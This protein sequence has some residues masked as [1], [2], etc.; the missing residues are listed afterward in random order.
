MAVL[1]LGLV[2]LC[3]GAVSI[4]YVSLCRSLEREDRIQWR[5]LGE[6]RGYGFSD[7]GKS[8][9]VYSWL[10]EDGHKQCGS[11][12]IQ[13]LGERA[14]QRARFTK[15]MLLSGVSLMVLGFGMAL[16]GF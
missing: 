5:T 2:L 16:A 15:Y 13:T 7:M 14:C 10:L 11:I 3:V 9:G 1:L 8:I 12:R 4:N 6:P